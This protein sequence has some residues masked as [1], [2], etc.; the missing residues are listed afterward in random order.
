MVLSITGFG[1]F[2]QLCSGGHRG[3]PCNPSALEVEEDHCHPQSLS[4]CECTGYTGHCMTA[5]DKTDQRKGASYSSI[6][7]CVPSGDGQEGCAERHKRG[8]Y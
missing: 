5:R 1:Y 6:P 4:E 8:P 3:T 7:H 2:E